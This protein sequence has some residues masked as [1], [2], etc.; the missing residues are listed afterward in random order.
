[1]DWFIA[2]SAGDLLSDQPTVGAKE[3]KRAKIPYHTIHRFPTAVR[4]RQH[5]DTPVHGHA[6]RGHG[7][8]QLGSHARRRERQHKPRHAPVPE[9]TA[10]RVLFV[11][12]LDPTYSTMQHR[13]DK[14][15]P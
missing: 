11:G 15:E 8:D 3:A 7:P 10:L 5:H 12:H 6:E 14:H 2:T 1:M 13:R 9:G 4:Q